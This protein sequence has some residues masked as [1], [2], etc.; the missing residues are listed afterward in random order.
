MLKKLG[1]PVEVAEAIEG[2]RGGM[3]Q[4]PPETLLD[5]LLLANHFAP[6]A[7]PLAGPDQQQPPHEDSVMDLFIDAEKRALMLEE[8]QA[9]ASAM[10]AALLV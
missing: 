9:D 6:I 5:T 3:L 10:T 8:A 7:S 4:I 2:L 1:I